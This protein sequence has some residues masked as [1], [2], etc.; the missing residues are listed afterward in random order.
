M[1]PEAVA[2]LVIRDMRKIFQIA[3]RKKKK[4]N[5]H[6]NRVRVTFASIADRDLVLGH[7]MHLPKDHSV[8]VVIPDFLQPLKRYLE[9]FAYKIRTKAKEVHNTKFSTSIRM[10]DVEMSLFLA[11]REKGLEKWKHY[12]RSQLEAMDEDFGTEEDNKGNSEDSEGESFGLMNA[13][14]TSTPTRERSRAK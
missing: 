6:E 1:E 13:T 12:T 5:S 9:K 10:D 14:V 2:S 3:G 7:A 4:G 8:D 11:T